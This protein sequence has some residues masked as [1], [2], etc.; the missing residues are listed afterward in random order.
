ML[1]KC[2]A[3]FWA[4]EGCFINLIRCKH[5]IFIQYEFSHILHRQTSNE[6]RLQFTNTSLFLKSMILSSTGIPDNMTFHAIYRYL[7]RISTSL[8]ICTTKIIVLLFYFELL[9]FTFSVF[10]G[11]EQQAFILWFIN[12]CFWLIVEDHLEVS[13]TYS[14][15]AIKRSFQR[16]IL[17]HYFYMPVHII[18]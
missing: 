16:L 11:N 18:N 1:H 5:F 17:S 10:W 6:H 12:A 7:G 13:N 9:F 15:K 8:S 2:F 4:H 3:T 14:R